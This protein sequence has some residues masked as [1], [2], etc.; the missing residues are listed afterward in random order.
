M[1]E[2]VEVRLGGGSVT[3]EMYEG[4]GGGKISSE[5]RRKELRHITKN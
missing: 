5:D 2:V 3:G 1:K 4:T